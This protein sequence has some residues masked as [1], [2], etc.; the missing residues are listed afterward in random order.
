MQQSL[1]TLLQ[2][3][4]G[5]SQIDAI[6]EAVRH[7]LGMEI[8]F[9]S[10]YV[11]GRR[12]F[13]HISTDLPLPQR[14]GDGDAVEDSY[15]WH[16]LQGRLPELIHNAADHPLAQSIPITKALPVGCHMDV[17]LRLKDGSVYG[18]FCCL[19]STPDYSLTER[20]LATLKVFS[21][22]AANQ[23]EAE[24]ETNRTRDETI[25]E[26]EA[27]IA[28]GQPAV[29]LQPIHR[30]KGRT[31]IGVE[32]LAR[33]PGDLPP[34]QW[35]GKAGRVG[36][37]AD[38]EYAAAASAIRALPYVPAPCYLAVNASPDLLVSG[39][40]EQ[41]LGGTPVGRIVV[42]ITEHA[43][44]QDYQTLRAALAPLA[45][46]VRIA[47]DDVGAGYS[48]LRH[49]LD[50][51]PDILK[52]DMSLTRDV[53]HDPARRALI[54]AMVRF[55]ESIRCTLVAEGIERQDELRALEELGVTAGQ[56]WYFSRALPPVKAQQYLLGAAAEPGRV[57]QRRANRAA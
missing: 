6:L 39:R 54:G 51:G 33:F 32:A 31:P 42:E 48:G 34:D 7:H 4:H 44:V 29:H 14:P 36:L 49:I 21:E 18:S 46:H 41:L 11:D 16:V 26:V 23:I 52:L 43:A 9:A 57:P 24:L 30:L 13:T 35:F 12:E 38:L 45:G 37:G 17:P 27:L 53:D 55:A 25:T 40:L 47:V 10:R 15:C 22:L 1:T 56:G 19:S 3:D 2:S 28:S 5:L 20:D 50:L 8:A